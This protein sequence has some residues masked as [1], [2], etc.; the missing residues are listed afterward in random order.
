MYAG[1]TYSYRSGIPKQFY[2]LKNHEFDDWEIP[3]WELLIY[4]NEELGHGSFGKVYKASWRGTPVVA[5]VANDPFSEK[6]K[7]LLIREFQA[8]T[9]LHHPNIIQLLGYV[10]EPFI[11][12]MDYIVNGDLESYLNKNYLTLTQKKNICIEILRALSYLHNRKPQHVIHRDI[13]MSNILLNSYGKVKLA[14]FGLSTLLLKKERSIEELYN[15]ENEEDSD[16]TNDVGTKRY[17]AP[18]MKSG[19]YT[20]KVDIWSTAILFIEIFEQQKYNPNNPIYFVPKEIKQIIFNFMLLIDYKKR[21]EC[22]KLITMF[23]NINFETE[24]KS[25]KCLCFL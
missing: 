2:H 17:M 8:M 24:K 5:K 1:S 11:I 3:P 10:K 6:Q 16:L 13:K 22:E 20:H 15:I 7:N 25:P 21:V 18:E 9:K 14:D 23:E 19:H 12:V 4:K